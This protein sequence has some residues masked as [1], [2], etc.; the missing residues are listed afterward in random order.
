MHGV[1]GRVSPD[2][3]RDPLIETHGK[4]AGAG[5]HVCIGKGIEESRI[6]LRKRKLQPIQQAAFP[7]LEPRA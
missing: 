2:Y 1:I 3:L 7:S 5:S 4:P 6:W